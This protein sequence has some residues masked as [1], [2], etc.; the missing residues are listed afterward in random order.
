MTAMESYSQVR[1]SSTT[2]KVKSST[3]T[4]SSSSTTQEVSEKK[5]NRKAAATSSV[6]TKTKEIIEKVEEK[7]SVKSKPESSAN[8]FLSDITPSAT[9]SKPTTNSPTISNTSAIANGQASSNATTASAKILK[10][11]ADEKSVE[12]YNQLRQKFEAEEK[13]RLE[14]EAAD[15]IVN[16][17]KEEE[18][19]QARHLSEEQ[20]P[21]FDKYRNGAKNEV[22]VKTSAQ[23]DYNK[24]FK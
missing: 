21:Q 11:K 23:E 6:S 8:S 1:R 7:A 17:K 13:I 14:K 9:I 20:A 19:R 16:A 15:K 4:P 10:Y 22:E 2:T 12:Y 18:A 24:L 5:D 3:S